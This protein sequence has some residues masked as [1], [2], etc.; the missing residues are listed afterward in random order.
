MRVSFDSN[1]WEALFDPG[2]TA[3][4][5]IRLALADGRVAGF[6]C[7]AGFRI[8]AITK[9]QRPAYFA[10]PHMRVSTKF[11][12]PAE[13]GVFRISM[14]IGPDDSKHPG[15]PTA[16]SAK[17]L[18]ALEAGVKLMRGQNRMGLPRPA[19]TLDKW[20]FV[21]ESAEELLEREQRQIDAFGMLRARG[22]GQAVFEAAD[23]WTDRPRPAAEEKQLSRACAEW[24]DGE[25]VKAPIAYR[26]DILCTN[27]RAGKSGRS[28]FDAANRAWLTAHYGVAFMT[29]GELIEAVTL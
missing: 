3:G 27:D 15:L 29:L 23:G 20:L 13:S 14:S 8:E 28:I 1:A 26:N 18:R 10:Q 17:L 4:A 7:E 24:A 9:L 22:V 2:D 12:T 6:I 25:S 21:L 19:A 11:E 16:Q 5:P